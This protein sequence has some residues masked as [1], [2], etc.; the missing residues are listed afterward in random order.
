MLIKYLLHILSV[1]CGLYSNYLNISCKTRLQK[2]KTKQ[3][4][5]TITSYILT[6]RLIDGYDN[7]TFSVT[8]MHQSKPISA[9]SYEI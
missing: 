3:N 4:K 5:S 1:Q 2:M 8:L 9:S 6:D 7:I